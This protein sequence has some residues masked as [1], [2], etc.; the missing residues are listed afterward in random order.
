MDLRDAHNWTALHHAARN[1]HAPAAAALLA[2]GASADAEGGL[3]GKV[4]LPERFRPL[5]MAAYFGHAGV[6]EALLAGGA[7]VHALDGSGQAPLFLATRWAHLAAVQALLAGGAR[8]R[9]L[10]VCGLD[11][12]RLSAVELAARLSVMYRF[13]SMLPSREALRHALPVD[14]FP[15]PE[16]YQHLHNVLRLSTALRVRE[17]K[18]KKRGREPGVGAAEG[19]SGAG[20]STASASHTPPLHASTPLPEAVRGPVAK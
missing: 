15:R 18:Q 16:A 10:S 8:P 2:A 5:H 6:V 20:Q 7:D 14:E 13:P 1:G 9:Q 12:H 3:R 11:R 19:G 17:R 4:R